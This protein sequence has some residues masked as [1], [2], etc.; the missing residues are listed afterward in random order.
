MIAP[1]DGPVRERQLDE[2]LGWASSATPAR[3]LGPH[4]HARAAPSVSAAIAPIQVGAAWRP[5]G[6]SRPS[7]D[8]QHGLGVPSSS[9]SSPRGGS[10]LLVR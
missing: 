3:G 7:G 4:A 8:D 5:T 2:A 9:S 6:S 1:V 10:A